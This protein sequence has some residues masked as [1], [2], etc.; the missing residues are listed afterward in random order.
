M[1]QNLVRKSVFD[2][3]DVIPT[4][5]INQSPYYVP[6]DALMTSKNQKNQNP[7]MQNFFSTAQ[8]ALSTTNFGSDNITPDSGPKPLA[9]PHHGTSTEH[10]GLGQFLTNTDRLL[11]VCCLN[12]FWAAYFGFNFWPNRLEL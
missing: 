3:T 5:Q 9:S 12:M 1:Y 2:D 10:M 6:T 8:S 4:P 11:G 7:K